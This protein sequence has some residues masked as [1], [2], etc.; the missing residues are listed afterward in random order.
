MYNVF[1]AGQRQ[2]HQKIKT[3]NPLQGNG[4]RV[5]GFLLFCG[6]TYQK[7]GRWAHFGRISIILEQKCADE[8]IPGFVVSA[9][10]LPLRLLVLW[11]PPF[12]Y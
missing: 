4:L 1:R 6:R 9:G 7:K 10:A 5:F 8:D 12:E 3:R 11:V 2:A